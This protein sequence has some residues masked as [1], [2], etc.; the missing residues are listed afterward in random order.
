M[1]K[2]IVLYEIGLISAICLC[3][4]TTNATADTWMGAFDVDLPVAIVPNVNSTTGELSWTRQIVSDPTN[5]ALPSSINIKGPQGATGPQGPQGPAGTVDQQALAAAV[6]TEINSRDL[7][8][9]SDL[10]ALSNTVNNSTT[11]L[12]A[13]YTIA[14]TA[15]TTA[16]NAASAAE[17]A[18]TNAQTAQGAADAVTAKFN[19]I[20]GAIGTIKTSAVPNLA[21]SHITNLQNTLDD[22]AAASDLTSLENT[23]NGETTCVGDRCTTTDGLNAQVSKLLNALQTAGVITYTNTNGVITI[24][25]I[26]QTCSC[27]SGGGS[28]RGGT[29]N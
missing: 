14:T 29:S 26:P 8:A 20:N 15:N 16:S 12:A 1:K 25:G 24:T 22:K 6:S 19:V 18:K 17:S 3:I 28:D 2:Q 23:V 7:A 5:V 9:A 27:S 11:G 13:T 21:I 10:T 4:A